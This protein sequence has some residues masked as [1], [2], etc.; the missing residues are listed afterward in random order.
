MLRLA[1]G[2]SHRGMPVNTTLGVIDN[3]VENYIAGSKTATNWYALRDQ[4]SV[5]NP[6]RWNEAFAE[7]FEARLKLR[8]LHPMQLLQ[9]N[10]ARQGEGFSI[11]ETREGVRFA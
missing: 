8:C 6:A 10:G 11:V 3:R 2:L 5:G 4:L 9:D 1:A 7:F